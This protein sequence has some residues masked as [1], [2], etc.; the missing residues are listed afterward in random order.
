MTRAAEA[1]ADAYDLLATTWWVTPER[2]Q[3]LPVNPYLIARRLGIQVVE[4]FLPSD[5]SGSIRREPG[6]TAVITLNMFDSPNRKRFTCAHELGHY[7][8]RVAEG[9]ED[10]SFTDFRSILAAAGTNA[11][12]VWANQFAA[13]LL[14]P[15]WLVLRWHD[16]GLG[17]DEMATLLG[18]STQAMNLRLR[19]LR[20]I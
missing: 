13:S 9:S 11:D 12:E 1:A 10:F 8:A 16:E 7:R 4:E 20:V 19:N 3:P 5:V 15:K 6:S 14:M 18:T 2:D 17:A